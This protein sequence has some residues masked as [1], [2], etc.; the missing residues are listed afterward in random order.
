[1]LIYPEVTVTNAR[2]E[3]RP[4]PVHYSGRDLGHQLLA[5]AG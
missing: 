3:L 4:D 1:M 2:G 5:A